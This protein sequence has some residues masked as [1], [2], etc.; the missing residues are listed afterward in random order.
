MLPDGVIRQADPVLLIIVP[1]LSGVF[2][3]PSLVAPA[4]TVAG[5]GPV[6]AALARALC[7]PAPPRSPSAQNQS[8]SVVCDVSIVIGQSYSPCF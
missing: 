7:H 2:V 3:L 8:V 5:D 4:D 1:D 6:I